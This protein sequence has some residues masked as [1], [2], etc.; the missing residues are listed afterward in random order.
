MDLWNGKKIMSKK[1]PPTWEGTNSL[2]PP[3]SVFPSLLK[4]LLNGVRDR[5]LCLLGHKSQEFL[6]HHPQSPS[7]HRQSQHVILLISLSTSILELVRFLGPTPPIRSLCQ[8]L[9]PP[10]LRTVLL[11]FTLNLFAVYSHMIFVQY[12]SLS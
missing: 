11:I 7:F 10:I 8:K 2:I 4:N 6:S 12:C 9:S 5:Q 1:F 3:P